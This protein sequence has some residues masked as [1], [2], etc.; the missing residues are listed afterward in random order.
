VARPRRSVAILDKNHLR[1]QIGR[2]AEEAFR[3]VQE[4]ARKLTPQARSAWRWRILYL[5][6]LIDREML[7]TNGRL[8]GSAL[9]NAFDE[10]TTI[11][12][13]EHVHS[14]PLHPPVTR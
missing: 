10:L 9:K 4:A 1:K 6:A 3:I 12:H 2:D 8:E 13:A 7:K 14:M 5:R 11:Y